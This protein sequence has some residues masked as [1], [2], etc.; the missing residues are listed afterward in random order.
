MVEQDC[1]D[2]MQKIALKLMRY[3]LYST[4]LPL[5]VWSGCYFDGNDPCWCLIVFDAEDP[6]TIGFLQFLFRGMK[7]RIQPAKHDEVA[8]VLSDRPAVIWCFSKLL[9]RFEGVYP[10]CALS[11]ASDMALPYAT[12][13]VGSVQTTMC[14]LPSVAE[15]CQSPKI[16]QKLWQYFL[17]LK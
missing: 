3:S 16:K 15:I 7:T 4:T 8:A 17:H 2:A 13:P 5:Q 9:D 1:R 12:L 11:A 6:D 14:L 10:S